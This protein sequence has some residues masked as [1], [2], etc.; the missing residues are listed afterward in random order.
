MNQNLFLNNNKKIYY[1]TKKIFNYEK[2]TYS[3]LN[4]VCKYI[5]G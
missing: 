1:S 4:L 5:N 3:F 2:K